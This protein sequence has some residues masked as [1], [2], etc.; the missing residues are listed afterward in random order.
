MTPS[1][2]DLTKTVI[3]EQVDLIKLFLLLL[4]RVAI[5]RT[6]KRQ[7]GKDPSRH[8][9]LSNGC[10]VEGSTHTH[11]HRRHTERRLNGR[12]LNSQR[13]EIKSVG[14]KNANKMF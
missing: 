11:T 8:N 7:G 13:F 4:E 5:G 1:G 6:D 12:K 14:R 2:S 9:N 3:R 10:P